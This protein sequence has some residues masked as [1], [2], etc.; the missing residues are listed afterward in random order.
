VLTPEQITELQA[1]L[2]EL[3]DSPWFLVDCEGDL[4]LWLETA[5]LN[6]T[7]DEHGNATGYRLPASY[8]PADLIAEW[9]LDTWDPGQ[10]TAD[11]QIRACARFMAAARTAV[12][13]LLAEVKQL[14]RDR[15]QAREEATNEARM[16][17]WADRLTHQICPKGE[18]AEWWA[19]SENHHAC[20][21]C[22]IAELEAGRERGEAQDRANA[23]EQQLR[24]LAGLA[25]E[26]ENETYDYIV[27]DAVT[28]LI[29]A[30]KG[31]VPGGE[32][33]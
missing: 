6:I 4:Q 14:T 15:D 28:A 8:K 22:R 11:D 24:Y 3:P 25:T 31:T 29:N 12:P 1:L 18:H 5:V 17:E 16:T 13:A 21:W 20:P 10:D 32:G 9:G 23:A 27:H 30:C 26:A 19:D 33:P 2:A 7:R